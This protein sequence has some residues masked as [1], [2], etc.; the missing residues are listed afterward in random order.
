MIQFF[1][2]GPPPTA[3]A[4]QKGQNRRT[5]SWYKTPELKDAE[6][7]Y[8]AYA[9]EARPEKPLEGAVALWVSFRYPI[10]KTGKH[11]DGEPKTTKPDTDN[12]IKALK[13]AMTKVGFWKDDAQVS[14]ERTE[15][16]YS[17]V[18]GIRVRVKGFE[19]WGL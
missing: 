19:E 6:Q 18:P 7:K 8:L 10:P 13:D 3:T 1:I 12:T 2:P 11:Y 14:N 16:I 17:T 15:K 4:Q 5:G 9:G